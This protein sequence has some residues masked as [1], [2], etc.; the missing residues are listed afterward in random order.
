MGFS[1]LATPAF[2]GQGEVENNPSQKVSCGRTP[3]DDTVVDEVLRNG[4]RHAIIKHD[5]Q[6]N[7]TFVEM[8]TKINGK[9]DE[10]K[11]INMQDQKKK[12]DAEPYLRIE[13]DCDNPP[14]ESSFSRKRRE[15]LE[16]FKRK[17]HENRPKIEEEAR[18]LGKDFGVDPAGIPK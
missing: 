17:S 12:R 9:K 16:K 4:T 13:K 8:V 10:K 18:Q 6:G 11:S 5:S 1:M 3:A 14:P 15:L 7:P 2:A